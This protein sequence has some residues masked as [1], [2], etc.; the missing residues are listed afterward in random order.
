MSCYAYRENTKRFADIFNRTVESVAGKCRLSVDLRFG[1]YKGHPVGHRRLAPMFPDF[2]DFKVDE[3]HVEM[4]NRE[5]AEIEMIGEIAKNL[6]NIKIFF[7]SSACDRE[8]HSA[9]KS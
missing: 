4:A 8:Q 5:F 2:L 9:P 3:M 7:L 6:L 1:N